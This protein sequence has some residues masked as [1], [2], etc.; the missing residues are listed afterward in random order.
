MGTFLSFIVLLFFIILIGACMITASD[1]HKQNQTDK[2]NRDS[3]LN[4][5]LPSGNEIDTEG[6][7]EEDKT[8]E[9]KLESLRQ[10][11]EDAEQAYAKAL[12]EISS[13]KGYRL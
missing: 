12:N 3:Y 11:R 8:P 7:W 1:W 4:N 5:L 9:Q 6:F 2:R 13:E 10:A